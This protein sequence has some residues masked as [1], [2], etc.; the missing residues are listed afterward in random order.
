MTQA[1]RS[2]LARSVALTLIVFGATLV[3]LFGLNGLVSRLP[4]ASGASS[5]APT[6]VAVTGPSTGPS[7]PPASV[8]ASQSSG[9]PVILAAGDIA[10]CSTGGSQATAALLDGQ[11]G[12]VV[13]LGDNAYP[14][15]SAAAYRDCYGP[16]WGR[17][18]DRTRPAPGDRDWAT[19][20]LAGYLG[21]FGASATTSG[22]PWYSFD[23]G[24]W[25]VIVLDSDCGKVAGCDPGS[26][27]GRW[28]AAD[29]A[30]SKSRCTLA[31]WHR[32]RFS[33][34]Q[35]GDEPAV[36][37]FWVALHAAGADVVLGAHDA[38][39]ERFAPQ[40]ASGRLDRDH[41]LREFV[42]GTGGAPLTDFGTVRPNSELR[43]SVAHGV[44]KLTLHATTYDWDFLSTATGFRDGGTATCH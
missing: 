28:L 19:A 2:P 36:A 27:Q 43:A 38:D 41:G 24:T 32:P 20:D 44:L 22:H 26:L 37:P 16:T 23:L 8:S 31:I 34:G 10:D 33:S 17:Q 1:T 39:Y 4:A 12:T 40:D 6:S 13:A 11:A 3:V 35:S 9:D 29:L 14:D 7:A 15:G 21:Y 30:A 5:L 25:H 18:L 42:V